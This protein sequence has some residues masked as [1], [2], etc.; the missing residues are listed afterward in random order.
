MLF[1]LL[2]A[3]AGVAVALWWVLLDVVYRRLLPRLEAWLWRR[4]GGADEPPS[5]G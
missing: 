4:L 1:V 2:L 5:R 3:L